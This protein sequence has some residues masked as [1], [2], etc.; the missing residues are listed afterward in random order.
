MKPLTLDEIDAALTEC[1][2]RLR[3][4]RQRHDVEALL[5]FGWQL[6]RL[7]DQRLALLH[8]GLIRC[9]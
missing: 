9:D 3:R 5:V 1:A 7:L 6:D 4:A 8:P 2:G